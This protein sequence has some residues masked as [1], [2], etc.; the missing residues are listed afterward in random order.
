MSKVKGV[1]ILFGVIL[2]T[3]IFYTAS[4]GFFDIQIQTRWQ[5]IGFNI[6]F[7]LAIILLVC[8]MLENV[9]IFS[10]TNNKLEGVSQ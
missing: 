10:R 3:S 9:A 2:L 6:L 7:G 1:F 5:Q 4:I 8:Y